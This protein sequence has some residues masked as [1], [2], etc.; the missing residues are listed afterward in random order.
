MKRIRF[1][2][3]T[4]NG[5][6]TVPDGQILFLSVVAGT[7]LGSWLKINESAPIF[8]PP[9]YT[10]GLDAK[11]FGMC[12]GEPECDR[13]PGERGITIVFGENAAPVSSDTRVPVPSDPP[14]SWLVVYNGC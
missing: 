10:L 5:Q 11:T 14:Q 3:G 8:V 6:T 9:G 13:Y 7:D 1:L 12:C 4:G 2:S